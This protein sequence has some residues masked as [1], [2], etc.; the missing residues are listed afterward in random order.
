MW[1]NRYLAINKRPFKKLNKWKNKNINF[2]A[3]LIESDGTFITY[4]KLVE[5]TEQN[6]NFLEFHQIKK[7]IPTDW[8]KI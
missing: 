4:D 3:D 6:I 5:K 8:K 7:A 1:N 2:I